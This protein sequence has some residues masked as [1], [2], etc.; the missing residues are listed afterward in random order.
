MRIY[1]LDRKNSLFEQ[2]LNHLQRENP[3][4]SVTYFTQDRH[5]LEA[6]RTRPPDQCFI[7]VGEPG[8]H[9][10]WTAEKVKEEAINTRMILVSE[11]EHYALR[12]FEIGVDDYWLE[13]LVKE[14]LEQAFP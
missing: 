13:P 5:F 2:T 9:G 11:E 4:L 7:R 8:I 1:L 14:K 12:A 6:V 10:L 3:A